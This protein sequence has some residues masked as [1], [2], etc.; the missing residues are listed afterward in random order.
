[1]E[2]MDYDPDSQN[3]EDH[4]TENTIFITVC[5]LVGMILCWIMYIVVYWLLYELTLSS[6]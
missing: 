5:L 6:Q 1:M 3:N 2:I 4:P